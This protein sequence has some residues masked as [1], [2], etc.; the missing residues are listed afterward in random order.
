ML[1]ERIGSCFGR[2]SRDACERGAGCRRRGCRQRLVS[3]GSRR[4]AGSPSVAEAPLSGRYL[5]FV[6]R[7]EIALLRARGRGRSGDQTVAEQDQQ[8]RPEVVFHLPRRPA[9]PPRDRRS[10]PRRLRNEHGRSKTKGGRWI[11][12][13]RWSSLTGPSAGTV[14]SSRAL[15][16]IAATTNNKRLYRAPTQGAQ[17]ALPAAPPQ[18][19]SPGTSTPGSAARPAPSSS[20]FVSSARSTNAVSAYAP[21][22]ASG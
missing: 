7:G 10:P 9:R 11:K 19:G 22:C 15:C 14:C 20:P 6:E 13:T 5:S 17:A 3:G 4:L 12:L 21:R 16:E 8:F 2:R 18:Q 1:A